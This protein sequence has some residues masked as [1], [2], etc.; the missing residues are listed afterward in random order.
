[1]R[2]SIVLIITIF[3]V[4]PGE[5]Q[6]L[7]SYLRNAGLV[8]VLDTDP[9][10]RYE[11]KYATEDNFLHAQV[12]EGITGIWLHPDAA[13]KL[14]KAQELL[15][16]KYPGYSL[17]IYDAARPMSVQQKMWDIAIRLNKT[18]YVS[19]PANGGGLHNYGMAVDLSIVDEN[20]TTLPMGTPFDYFGE[21]AHINNEEQLLREGKISR[22]ELDNRLLLRKIM[23]EAGFRTIIYEWWH[24]NACSR[25]EARQH[26]TLIH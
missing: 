16:Q 17:I 23:R 5:A 7:D 15:K 6:D 12:Y 21:E 4:L 22:R 14:I 26:Y 13:A 20:S 19:N 3:T 25:E 11:L 9:S 8:N 24:F 1:M 10:I 2:Y 18:N